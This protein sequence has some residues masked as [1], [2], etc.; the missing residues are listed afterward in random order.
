MTALRRCVFE[1]ISQ[2]GSVEDPDVRLEVCLYFMLW[3][4]S[5]PLVIVDGWSLFRVLEE[6]DTSISAVGLMT[7]LP[8]GSVPIEMD[9]TLENGGLQ[10]TARVGSQDAAWLT[11]PESKRYNMVYLYAGGDREHPGW[12]WAR[13]FRGAF[14]KQAQGGQASPAHADT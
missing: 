5:D 4:I 11:Y 8:A 7:L 6:T 10:W 12:E 2:P 1:R 14:P 3:S 13:E 9:I